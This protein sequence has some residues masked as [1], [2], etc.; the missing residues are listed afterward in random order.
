MP[1][2]HSSTLFFLIFGG[3]NAKAPFLFLFFLGAKMQKH[4]FRIGLV[5]NIHF[6]GFNSSLHLYEIFISIKLP[7]FR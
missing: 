4:P 2:E 7:N 1:L 5:A 6:G 3:Q